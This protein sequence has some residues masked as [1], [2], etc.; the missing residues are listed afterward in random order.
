MRAQ[1]QSAIK[2]QLFYSS[3]GTDKNRQDQE[4]GSSETKYLK[5]FLQMES[6]PGTKLRRFLMYDAY[7]VTFR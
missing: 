6:M 2:S 7:P 4:L 1:P 3:I 5:M